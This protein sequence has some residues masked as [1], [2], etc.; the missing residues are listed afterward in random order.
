MTAA[1]NRSNSAGLWI[2]I[3][4]F[5]ALALICNAVIFALG[6]DVGALPPSK[7]AWLPPGIGVGLIWLVQFA[8]MGVSRWFYLR[9][10]N[11]RGWRSWL[12]VLLAII[13]LAFPAYTGGLNDPEAGAA[14]TLVTLAVTVATMLVLGPGSSR[15][16]W[17]LVPLAVWGSY[18]ACVYYLA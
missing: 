12:P 3:A 8:L 11:D 2:N 7:E 17:A 13:C 16:A 15:A 10:S 18:V 6:L 5:V 14:G 9:D 1:A 4:A